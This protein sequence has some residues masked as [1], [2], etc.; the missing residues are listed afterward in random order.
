MKNFKKSILTRDRNYLKSKHTVILAMVVTAVGI[1]N[2][3]PIAMALFSTFILAYLSK[4]SR[5][6]S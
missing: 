3:Y 4:G 2:F 1:N 6:S 5:K